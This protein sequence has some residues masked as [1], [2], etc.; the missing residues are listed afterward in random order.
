[1]RL[2]ATMQNRQKNTERKLWAL[3]YGG[4]WACTLEDPR[5]LE[6]VCGRVAQLAGKDLAHRMHEISGLARVDFSSACSRWRSFAR[7]QRMK[8]APSKGSA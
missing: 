8:P 2:R 4:D 5:S 3:L 1:L 6:R 7:D